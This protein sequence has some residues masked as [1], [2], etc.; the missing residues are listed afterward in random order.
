[1]RSSYE[2]EYDTKHQNS[3]TQLCNELYQH[4]IL[5]FLLVDVQ[6]QSINTKP[7][8]TAFLVF[9]VKIV[10]A[11]HFQVLCDLQ[12]L[13]HGIIPTNNGTN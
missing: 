9:D 3:E 13:H 7:E 1:M 2:K 5:V 11:V 8:F 10:D 6:P 4:Y 12:I